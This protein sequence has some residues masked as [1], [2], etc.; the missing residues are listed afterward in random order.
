LRQSEGDCPESKE[1]EAP[2]S[3]IRHIRGRLREGGL[4]SAR[5]D[6]KEVSKTASLDAGC[7]RQ[8]QDAQDHDETMRRLL[9]R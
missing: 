3:A 2:E 7:G 6:A 1:F 8:F 9:K 5:L 4:P